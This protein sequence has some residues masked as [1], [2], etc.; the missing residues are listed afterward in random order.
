[1]ILSP[2]LGVDTHRDEHVMAVVTAPAGAVVAGAGLK[3][4]NRGGRTVMSHADE[5]DK[6]LVKPAAGARPAPPHTC[7]RIVPKASRRP[8]T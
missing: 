8:V 7:R 6:L 5:A 4:G 1:L 3:Q 2:V